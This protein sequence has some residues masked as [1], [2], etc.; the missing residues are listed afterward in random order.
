[1][2]D[3]F[4]GQR[5]IVLPQAIRQ[6]MKGD[7]LMQN[8]HITDIGHYPK[9]KFH[10][11]NRPQGTEEYIFLYCI[12]GSGTCQIDTVSHSINAG[13][14]I[15]LPAGTGHRY[16]SSASDPWTIYW[17]HFS[18]TQAPYFAHDMD[19]PHDLQPGTLTRI[20]ERNQLFEEMYQTLDRSF[21]HESLCYVTTLLYRYLGTLTFIRE[22]RDATDS[23]HP[24]SDIDKYIHYM[25]ENIEKP[26]SLDEMARFSGYSA[27]HFSALFKARTGY[28]PLTYFNMLK[29]QQACHMLTDSDMKISQ[30]CHKVGIGDVFY[31][32][33]LFHKIMGMAPQDYRSSH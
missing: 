20:N 16:E 15:I 23:Q 4:N 13:Q 21:A 22:Y 30:I 32:S 31:F 27:S 33:R 2:K 3:G 1:M 10:L 29:I 17:F 28:P 14:Y 8:L 9:A 6:M 26:L 18:G 5:M 11:I 25:K 12:A 19:S 24:H 7:A